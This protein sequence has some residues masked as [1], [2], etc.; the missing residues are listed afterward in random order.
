MSVAIKLHE[1]RSEQASSGYM[2]LAPVPLLTHLVHNS[3]DKKRRP[4]HLDLSLE[5]SC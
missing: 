4:T 2:Q 5:R 1:G 3:G